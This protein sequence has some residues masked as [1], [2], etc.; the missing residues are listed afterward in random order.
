M[1]NRHAISSD[2]NPMSGYR[3]LDSFF[4]SHGVDS[5]GGFETGV[6]VHGSKE[7][8]GW[9]GGVA[10]DHFEIAFN[11]FL[12]TEQS[13]VFTRGDTCR[14]VNVHDNV[15]RNREPHILFFTKARTGA[16][17]SIAGRKEFDL[18]AN[19]FKI[20][21]PTLSTAAGDFDGDGV[22]DIFV[23]TGAGWYFSSG[24]RT[25]WR[26]LNRKPEKTI[27]LRFGGF[28]LDGRTDVV[29]VH[30]ADGQPT[31]SACW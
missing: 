27:D 28:D 11:T 5:G 19:K 30:G 18:E 6:D 31:A 29:A 23:G 20:K 4:L 8:G 14:I 12:G 25:E 3:A 2:G 7:K 15:T 24:G 17:G 16:F 21:D 9:K 10:G 13:N 1:H 26:F 22:D